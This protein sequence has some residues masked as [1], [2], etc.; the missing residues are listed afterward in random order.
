MFIHFASTSFFRGRSLFG[1]MVLAIFSLLLLGGTALADLSSEYKNKASMNNDYMVYW[2]YNASSDMMYIAA[3][4]KATG[5]VSFA[6]TEAKSSNMKDYDACIG[7]VSGG[8]KDLK[9]STIR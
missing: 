4:V 9:V 3:E 5:W 2:T 7:S 8:S 1:K 6:F